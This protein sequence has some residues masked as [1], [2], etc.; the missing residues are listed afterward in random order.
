MK[1]HEPRHDQSQ[2]PHEG[3]E[4][5]LGFPINPQ[6]QPQPQQENPFTR[7][8]YL[9]KMRAVYEK[10]GKLFITQVMEGLDALLRDRIP[11]AESVEKSQSQELSSHLAALGG[12]PDGQYYRMGYERLRSEGYVKGLKDA[13]EVLYEHITGEPARMWMLVEDEP[14]KGELRE[15]ENDLKKSQKTLRAIQYASPTGSS[16]AFCLLSP[17][18]SAKGCQTACKNRPRQRNP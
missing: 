9:E 13:F 12:K 4:G 16:L 5:S 18:R 17:P 1:D 10:D 7:K 3:S 11:Q 14:K 2:S 15:G 6:D 8:R